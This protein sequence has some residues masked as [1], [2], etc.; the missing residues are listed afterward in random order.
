[1]GKDAAAQAWLGSLDNA[2][3]VGDIVDVTSNIEAEQAR[4]GR[5]AA[6]AVP[7]P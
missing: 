6:P 3:D 7:S 5:L 4:V 2:P 1:V